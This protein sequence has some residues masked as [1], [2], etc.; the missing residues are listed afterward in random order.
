LGLDAVV[1]VVVVVGVG[2]GAAVVVIVVG[3]AVVSKGN[4]GPKES[5]RS[6]DEASLVGED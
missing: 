2:L 5:L 6:D 1:V 4:H 3:G